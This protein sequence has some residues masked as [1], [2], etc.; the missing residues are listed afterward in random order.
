MED[1]TEGTYERFTY[2]KYS[3]HIEISECNICEPM[4]VVVIPDEIA[5]LPVT[6]IG[7]LA[8]HKCLGIIEITIP[9]SVIYIGSDAF[10]DSDLKKIVIENPKCKPN[11]IGKMA[12]IYGYENSAAQAYA[13][14]YKRKFVSLGEAPLH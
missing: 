10:R 14:R 7:A 1:Y 3:G 5:G 8:F 6:R 12:T 13:K 9:D 11:S 2:K 4:A